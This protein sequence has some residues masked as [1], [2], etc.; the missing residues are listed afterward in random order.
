MPHVDGVV[1]DRLAGE[2][3]GDRVDLE[4]V[5]VQD[6]DVIVTDRGLSPAVAQDYRAAGVRLEIADPQEDA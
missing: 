5:A 1:A 3:V 4:A 6:L 2:V